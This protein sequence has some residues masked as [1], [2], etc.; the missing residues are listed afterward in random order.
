MIRNLTHSISMLALTPEIGELAIQMQSQ[1]FAHGLGRGVGVMDL[2]HAATAVAHDVRLVHYDADFE[3]L[4]TCWPEL[5]Q[6]W[7]VPRG[8]AD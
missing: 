6:S 7:V 3:Q 8:S 1:L 5:D 2:L 4:A